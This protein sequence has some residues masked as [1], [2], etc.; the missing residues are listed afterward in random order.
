MANTQHLAT[1]LAN[2]DT[3]KSQKQRPRGSRLGND[4]DC[5]SAYATYSTRISVRALSANTTARSRRL[6]RSEAV[7]TPHTRAQAGSG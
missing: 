5:D 3:A 2:E 1:W 7:P 4:W 6:A